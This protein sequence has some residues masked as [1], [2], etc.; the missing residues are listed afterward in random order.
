ML[1]LAKDH[2]MLGEALW[3]LRAWWKRE[4]DSLL[5]WGPIDP[6]D[7]IRMGKGW[8]YGPKPSPRIKNVVVDD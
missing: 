6:I 7:T 8:A 3:L 2:P 1:R 5:V 4:F